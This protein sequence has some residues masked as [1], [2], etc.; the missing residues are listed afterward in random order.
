[1]SCPQYDNISCHANYRV[2]TAKDAAALFKGRELYIW[3]AG[4]KGRGFMLALKRNGFKVKAFLDKSPLLIGTEYQGIPT[5]D[6]RQILDSP[7]VLKNSFIL[8]ASVDKK[9]REMFE[10]CCNAGLIKGKDFVNIQELSP[11]YPCVEISGVCNLKCISCPRGNS[12]HPPEKGGFMNVLD[13]SSIIAKLIKEI[14]FLY[15]VD[16]Y[17]WGEPLLNP[18]LS[19]IIKINTNLGIASGISSNLNVSR[20]L[21]EVIKAAPAQIRVSVSGYGEKNYE[22]T[23]K[24]ARW[25]LLHANLKL[26]SEYIKKYKTNTIVEVYYH[27]YKNNVDEYRKIRELCEECGFRPLPVIAML[28]ADYALDF[29]EGNGLSDEAR[30]AEDLML[31]KLKELVDNG[32]KDIDKRCLLNR[33]LPIINWDMSVMPCCNY[34]YRKLADNYLDVSL[35]DIIELR[36]THSLCVKCQKYSLHRYFNPEYYSGYVNKLVASEV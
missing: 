14:P 3:G 34:S 30:K 31:I 15:L 32:K 17:I 10:S 12:A 6:P 7:S 4:Q 23:H 2:Y 24:G 13:Y 29:C 18:E 36:K 19:E 5:F 25:M 21:E 27:V 22:I 28:L 8:T 9:N 16:L 33:V 11:F 1:M 20:N 26:L 35:V